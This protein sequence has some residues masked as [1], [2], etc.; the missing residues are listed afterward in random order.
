MIAGFFLSANLKWKKVILFPGAFALLMVLDYPPLQQMP[1]SP[2]APVYSALQREKG[3]CGTGMGFPFF[4]SY[5]SQ[6][7]QYM[8]TQRMRGSDCP[9]LNQLQSV[10][11]LNWLISHFPPDSDFIAS[12]KVRPE[13]A[14]AVVK[15]A[16]C[17]PLNWIVFHEVTPRDWAEVLCQRLGWQFYSDMSCVAAQK[18]RPLQNYPEN[19]L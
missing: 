10:D 11:R 15:I 5:T 3:P 12:L 17:V 6:S 1:M 2:I 14:E 19:C 4:N 18:G 7:A 16:N 13:V 8:F 9:S